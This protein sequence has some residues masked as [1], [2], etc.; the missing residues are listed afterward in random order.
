M[1][2]NDVGCGQKKEENGGEEELVCK[3]CQE[4]KQLPFFYFLSP[5]F[6]PPSVV[7]ATE[8]TS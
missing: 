5:F 6:N 7:F 8:L 4:K 3:R 1:V 2:G